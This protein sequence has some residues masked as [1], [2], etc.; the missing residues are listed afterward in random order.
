M[1]K[2]E[3][4]FFHNSSSSSV[5]EILLKLNCFGTICALLIIF[6][7]WLTYTGCAP[8]GV[9]GPKFW[10]RFFYDLL[11]KFCSTRKMFE[12]IQKTKNLFL[13]QILRALTIKNRTTC[14]ISILT[15]FP[16]KCGMVGSLA[17]F[18][19][20][21]FHIRLNLLH[22]VQSDNRSV[23]SSALIGHKLDNI[24]GAHF[25]KPVKNWKIGGQL[26]F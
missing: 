26:Y 3:K 21:L 7:K 9:C 20:N 24:K 11:S 19:E 13:A 12:F 4:F 14:T 15:K 18:G 22:F 23:F 5:Q 16:D 25:G 8:Y 17:V 10:L 2:S 6:G 1:W